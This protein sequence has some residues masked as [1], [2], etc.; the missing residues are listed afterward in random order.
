[1]KRSL[2]RLVN[3]MLLAGSSSALP[4]GVN[5]YTTVADSTI[6]NIEARTIAVDRAKRTGLPVMRA[7]AG[8]VGAAWSIKG[9]SF[10]QRFRSQVKIDLYFSIF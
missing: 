8:Y 7:M 3:L 6:H 2:R 5:T 1:M 4:F 9:I 10:P